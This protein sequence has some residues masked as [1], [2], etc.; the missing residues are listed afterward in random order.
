MVKLYSKDSCMQCRMTKK[1]LDEKGV[2][3]S[4]ID[5]NENK[6]ERTHLSLLG[7]QTVPVVQYTGEDG[8]DNFITGFA[9]NKLEIM[10]EGM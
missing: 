10:K 4:Y 7:F 3:Y 9:P 5:I 6:A 8:K 2:D 1:W